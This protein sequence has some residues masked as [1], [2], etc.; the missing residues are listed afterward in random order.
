MDLGA[1]VGIVI[2]LPLL[3]GRNEQWLAVV[4]PSHPEVIVVE[5]GHLPGH[6]SITGV[7]WD[8][9][10]CFQ[11]HEL[12][13]KAFGQ[14]PKAVPFGLSWDGHWGR[15]PPC[16]SLPGAARSAWSQEPCFCPGEG[17]FWAHF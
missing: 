1:R 15:V 7:F 14:Y 4:H 5:L 3:L 13:M 10:G 8:K 9:A 11:V 12:G 17:L 16:P 6:N 2:P